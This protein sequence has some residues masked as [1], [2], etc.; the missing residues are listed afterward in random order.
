MARSS[1]QLWRAA[2]TS[3]LT[4]GFGSR[5]F[6]QPHCGCL[7]SWYERWQRG[8]APYCCDATAGITCLPQG[9]ARVAQAGQLN[10]LLSDAWS[11]PGILGEAGDAG[12]TVAALA[13]QL[14]LLPEGP[15]RTTALN[16]FASVRKPS[17]VARDGIVCCRG[18]F[19]MLLSLGARPSEWSRLGEERRETLA[20]ALHA[21]GAFE[22]LPDAAE[23]AAR[24]DATLTSGTIDPS[25][26]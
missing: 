14:H 13:L 1:E 16:R 9:A 7:R 5:G 19:K 17:F 10:E 15:E 2:Q 26:L 11:W 25:M 3:P 18:L 22:G 21:A 8:Q 4:E 12:L 24:A 23:L 6:V 20:A